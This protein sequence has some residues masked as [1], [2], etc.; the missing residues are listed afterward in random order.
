[1]NSIFRLY[2]TVSW[3]YRANIRSDLVKQTAIQVDIL[4]LKNMLCLS[5][6]LMVNGHFPYFRMAVSCGESPIFRHAKKF[7][8]SRMFARSKV[9]CQHGLHSP[10]PEQKGSARA[11][12][13]SI[14][15]KYPCQSRK[16]MS[17]IQNN[18]V[19]S[20]TIHW[21]C[22][23]PMF[24]YPSR[25]IL[26][27]PRRLNL[28]K[29]CS[30]WESLPQR[31][32]LY[33]MPAAPMVPAIQRWFRLSPKKDQRRHHGESSYGL[34]KQLISTNHMCM[35]TYIYIHTNMCNQGTTGST[36]ISLQKMMLQVWRPYSNA[37]NTHLYHANTSVPNNLVSW[38]WRNSNMGVS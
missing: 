28:F 5:Q 16:T 22:E 2:C 11:W 12:N 25:E 35:H 20:T 26:W 29:T 32:R 21:N 6:N 13:W 38:T 37:E 3:L 33:S 24:T 36:G 8:K 1:M 27:S 23:Y 7:T 31:T 10:W 19:S 17:T 18:P 4:N 30:P 15:L 14:A 34:G 9:W